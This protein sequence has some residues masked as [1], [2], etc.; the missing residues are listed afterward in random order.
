MGP[1]IGHMKKPGRL[2]LIG[3][4]VH[5]DVGAVRGITVLGAVVRRRVVRAETADRPAF[6]RIGEELSQLLGRKVHLFLH[7][8]TDER[9]SEDKEM[10]EEMGLEWKS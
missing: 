6:E 4:V 5:G 1:E 7:V 2:A 8:K 3:H 10:F 9:W